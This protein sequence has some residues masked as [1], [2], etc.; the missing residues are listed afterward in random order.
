MSAPDPATF[1]QIEV[2]PAPVSLQDYQAYTQASSL[3][4]LAAWTPVH[5]SPDIPLLVTC[6]FFTVYAPA[7]P[8]VGRVLRPNDCA[9]PDASAVAVIGEELWRSRFGAD[10]AIVGRTLP[11]NG[12]DFSRIRRRSAAQLR[13]SVA[14]TDLGALHDGVSVLRRPCDRA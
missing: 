2:Q 11:L 10:L 14:R 1:F 8:L 7:Q 12:H 6:N 3:R 5:A 4:S 9:A 13:R